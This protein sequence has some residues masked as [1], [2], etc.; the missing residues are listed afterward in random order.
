MVRINLDSLL[1]MCMSVCLFVPQ[2]QTKAL[3]DYH[4]IWKKMHVDNYTCLFFTSV[5]LLETAV[6]NGLNINFQVFKVLVK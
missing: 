3:A 2:L 6:V 5:F 1:S 4:V